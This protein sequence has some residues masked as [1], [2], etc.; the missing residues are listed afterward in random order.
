MRIIIFFFHSE[1]VAPVCTLCQ[2]KKWLIKYCGLERRTGGGGFTGAGVPDPQPDP[3][4]VREH[5]AAFPMY[6]HAYTQCVLC[7]LFL[8]CAFEFPNHSKG[9]KIIK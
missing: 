6:G 8:P 1:K 4:Q 5:P 3:A 7:Q 9:K 2:K